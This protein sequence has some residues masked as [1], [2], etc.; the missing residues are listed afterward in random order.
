MRTIEIFDEDY[1]RLK[2]YGENFAFVIQEILDNKE[3]Q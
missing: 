2:K 1:E 3:V